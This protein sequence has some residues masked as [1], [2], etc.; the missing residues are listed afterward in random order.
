LRR[1][2][3]MLLENV[4]PEVM[5]A[6]LSAAF[7]VPRE[8]Q[9]AQSP[10]EAAEGRVRA[11]LAVVLPIWEWEVRQRVADDLRAASALWPQNFAWTEDMDRA[12]KIAEAGLEVWWE[13]YR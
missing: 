10:K 6:A 5:Q 8:V 12:A 7:P 2:D 4:P 3:E 9:V 13:E 1:Q 11:A